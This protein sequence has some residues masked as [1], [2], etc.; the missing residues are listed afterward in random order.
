M[1]FGERAPQLC[2]GIERALGASNATCTTIC[3]TI[4]RHVCIVTGANWN[5]FC[6]LFSHSHS[7]RRHQFDM[8]HIRSGKTVRLLVCPH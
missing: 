6:Q 8:G 2:R 3:V 1:K 4:I 7:G 5:A